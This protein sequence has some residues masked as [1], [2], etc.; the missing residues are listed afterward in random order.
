MGIPLTT[1]F[2]PTQPGRNGFPAQP[3]FDVAERPAGCLLRQHPRAAL[4]IIRT[5]AA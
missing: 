3:A 4:E 5:D 2:G 1:Y